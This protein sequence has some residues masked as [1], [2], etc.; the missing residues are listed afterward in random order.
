MRTILK[1]TG[2]L[3]F[4]GSGLVLFFGYLAFLGEW[5]GFI[6]YIIGV[7]IMPGVI[8][9]PL[10]VWLKTGMFPVGY[11]A[12]WALGLLGG[13]FCFFLASIGEKPRDY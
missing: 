2:Y 9:F 1:G 8:I 10:I 3:L 11:F 5:F 4:Y 7:V 6:G 12:I 13:Y